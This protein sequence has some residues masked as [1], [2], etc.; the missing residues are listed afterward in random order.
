MN[1]R[2]LDDVHR[3]RFKAKA[4]TFEAT[5]ADVAQLTRLG[6]VSTACNHHESQLRNANKGSRVEGMQQSHERDRALTADRLG[7]GLSHR[8][9]CRS[10]WY[11][12]VGRGV[13]G[14][15]E[16]YAQEP[17]AG[18]NRESSRSLLC[19]DCSISSS[20]EINK[21]VAH[22][23]SCHR[24]ALKVI[25]IVCRFGRRYRST[26]VLGTATTTAFLSKRQP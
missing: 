25:G 10:D 1:L 9:A 12:G 7:D 13:V 6:A 19:S 18:T 23:L 21:V 3:G 5:H 4:A 17:G 22:L 2:A 14:R 15:F 26:A 16:Q 11:F 24:C 20:G 8:T